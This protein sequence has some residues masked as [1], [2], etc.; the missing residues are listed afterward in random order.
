MAD[1]VF[2]LKRGDTKPPLRVV[3]RDPPPAGSAPGTPGPI[4]DLTGSTAWKLHIKL[5]NGT[6]LTR[7]LVVDGPPT[8]GAAL[9]DWVSGDWDP[10]GLIVGP[11]P[12]LKPTDIEHVMEYEVLGPGSAR[13]TF[14]NDG[15]HILRIWQDLGQG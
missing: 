11:M 2:T 5:N 15:Y 10:G 4:H 14:P 7:N 12:P 1:K 6:V 8:G 13:F 3:F 9:Y